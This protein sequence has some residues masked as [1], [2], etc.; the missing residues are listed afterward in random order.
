M[1]FG[2][3]EEPNLYFN[4]ERIEVVKQYKYV[5]A[6]VSPHKTISGDTFAKN[7]D[8]L[9]AQARKASFAMTKRLENASPTPMNLQISLFDTLV[10][11][12]LT[13]SSE[14]WGVRKDARD[15][16]DVFFKQFLKY[17]MRV[18]NSTSDII[19]YG[20]T[21]TFPISITI[22]AN[23]F[24]FYHRL[25]NMSDHFLVKKVFTSLR[26]LSNGGFKTWISEVNSLASSN[27]IS[28]DSDENNKVF[29]R[30]CKTLLET[31]FKEDWLMQV[32]NLLRWYKTANHKFRILKTLGS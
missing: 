20:E 12:I 25:S 5:G 19:V 21:G 27:N 29:K 7:T 11:S 2:T 18:K 1:C 26:H 30:K 17:H 32:H 10:K 13:Y 28:L 14:I 16:I 8:Y 31:Q 9:C 4:G 3:N 24:A 22:L 15:Q 6:L 23:I